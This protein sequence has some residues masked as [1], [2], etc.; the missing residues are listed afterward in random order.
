MLQKILR[1]A[2]L[3]NVG[4]PDA[5]NVGRQWRCGGDAKVNIV[6]ATL[7]LDHGI[8][9]SRVRS[10]WIENRFGVSRNSTIPLKVRNDRRGVNLQRFLPCTDD[11]EGSGEE[12]GTR[13][14]KL[15][16]MDE[17]AAVTKPFLDA[18]VAKDSEGDGCFPD[19]CCAN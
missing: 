3:D 2:L 4:I 13:G 19:S 10:L 14:W 8:Y 1:A 9:I 16:A 15:I 5:W 6:E 18:I 7:L 17:S 12:V 11:L